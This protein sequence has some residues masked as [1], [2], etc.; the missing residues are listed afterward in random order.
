MVSTNSLQRTET[1]FLK[2]RGGGGS[3]LTAP[4]FFQINSRLSRQLTILSGGAFDGNAS[5]ELDSV[6]D[7]FC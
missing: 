2:I 4:S 5:V 1:E 3:R 6:V 7:S